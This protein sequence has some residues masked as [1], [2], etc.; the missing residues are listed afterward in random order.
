MLNRRR[1]LLTLSGLAFS[2]L[3]HG[4]NAARLP[5]RPTRKSPRGTV[6]LT[7]NR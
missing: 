7:F 2:P 1:A 3:L 5:Y 6:T 4:Q